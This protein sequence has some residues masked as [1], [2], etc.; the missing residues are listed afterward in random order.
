MIKIKQGTLKGRKKE[1]PTRLFRMAAFP[2]GLLALLADM[3]TAALLP[4]ISLRHGKDKAEKREKQTSDKPM[5]K[6]L[7]VY[8]RCA[9]T[10]Q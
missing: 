1:A 6:K 10:A 4:T 7:D 3:V 5:P 8:N 9:T 2:T